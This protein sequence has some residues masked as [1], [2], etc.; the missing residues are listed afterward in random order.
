MSQ[1]NY[2]YLAGAAVAVVAVVSLSFG[3]SG[4]MFQGSLPQ[5]MPSQDECRIV[6]TLYNAGVWT[7]TA[8]KNF[9]FSGGDCT[10]LYG[11]NFWDSI[12]EEAPAPQ[13]DMCRL[14]KT[15]YNAG[16]WTGMAENNFG[17]DGGD[18]I[19]MWGRNYWDSITSTAPAPSQE[20]CR[21]IKTL[22][23][24]GV[25]TGTA[26]KNFNFSG[27][28]C[29]KLYGSNFWDSVKDK[30]VVP[31]QEQCRLI[32]TYYN[33]GTWT[34]QLEHNYN[35][36]GGDCINLYGRDYWN[37]I[38]QVSST[39][40]TSTTTSTTTLIAAQKCT[41]FSDVLSNNIYY[42]AVNYVRTEG[43][44]D[45]YDDC[46]FRPYDNINRAEFTKTLVNAFGL[47]YP[48]GDQSHFTDVV[49]GTWYYDFVE[50]AFGKQIVTGYPD[51]GFKPGNLINNAETAKIFTLAAGIDVSQYSNVFDYCTNLS[52]QEKQ[53][54]YYPYMAALAA[55]NAID[56][57]NCQP[58]ASTTRAQVADIFFRLSQ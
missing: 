54:W 17:Y 23:N 14:V 55:K 9:G 31:T 32:R 45:G 48:V 10:N 46:T 24:A 15:Y 33:A 18:C 28:D 4:S 8:D 43:I 57:Y 1:K 42:D 2:L 30:A 38:K 3:L 20:V 34:G 29:T 37:S 52:P 39:T 19:N 50:I 40:T 22:Y 47:E 13:Q 41:S 56:N 51:G 53:A 21:I 44:F 5:I 6:K 27:G 11:S 49:F 36:N 35:Y 58:A 7:G 25:W 12:K 16:T 26:D